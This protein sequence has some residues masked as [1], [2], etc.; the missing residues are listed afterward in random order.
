MRI[1]K[2]TD[3]LSNLVNSILELDNISIEKIRT[4]ISVNSRIKYFKFDKNVYTKISKGEKI[5]FHPLLSPRSRF[6]TDICKLDI[7]LL[8]KSILGENDDKIDLVINEIFNI[9]NYKQTSV[10]VLSLSELLSLYAFFKDIK[11]KYVES[12][13]VAKDEV[14]GSKN[15]HYKAVCSDVP[16]N[17]NYKVLYIIPKKKYSNVTIDKIPTRLFGLPTLIR[18][19][20]I[21]FNTVVW[22]AVVDAN[23]EFGTNI[24]I[25]CLVPHNIIVENCKVL[26]SAYLKRDIV[27]YYKNNINKLDHGYEK[28]SIVIN[29]LICTIL[30]RK[31]TWK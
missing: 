22:D 4:S 1:T 21:P 5:T 16:R 28:F 11:S 9:I 2:I 15:I 29:S 31:T 24:A 12:F 30:A 6:V 25:K 23:K 3:I 7:Y 13:L 18:K 10:D 26:N 14:Y 8:V 19:D 27:R 17:I 20:G